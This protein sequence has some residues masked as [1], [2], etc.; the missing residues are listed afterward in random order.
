MLKFL[1]EMN[2]NKQT[3]SIVTPFT[4]ESFV[5]LYLIHA[6]MHSSPVWLPILF[7]LPPVPSP[8]SNLQDN[9]EEK[10]EKRIHCWENLRW[11]NTRRSVLD[12]EKWPVYFVY[13]SRCIDRKTAILTRCVHRLLTITKHPT[14]MLGHTITPRNI[15]GMN[16]TTT[17]PL[18]PNDFTTCCMC[19]TFA[20]AKAVRLCLRCVTIDIVQ[21]DYTTVLV[22]IIAPYTE[23]MLDRTY[24]NL[25]PI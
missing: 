12:A 9:A 15:F 23:A 24:W 16:V 4:L 25:R 18:M 7:S 8:R 5:F 13:E 3:W 6:C 20:P 14:H 1:L 21:L 17:I 22:P 19:V 10:N 11:R 2:K